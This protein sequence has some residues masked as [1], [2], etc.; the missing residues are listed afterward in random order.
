MSIKIRPYRKG[1]Y[2]VDIVIRLPNGQT[3]RER[4]KSPFAAK[5]ATTHWAKER[6]R[7]LL[8]HGLTPTQAPKKEV[9][10]LAEFI[11][12]YIEGYCKANRL[13][14]AT[15]CQR[16]TVSTIHLI[17][18]L[19][20]KRLDRIKPEDIQRL[21]A[22]RA[23]LENVTVNLML[24]MLRSVLNV[25]LEWGVIDKVPV[26]I[27]KLKE[28]PSA[29][30]FYD[31]DEFDKLVLAAERSADPNRL[32]SVLLGGEAGLRCSE[33]RPLTWSDLDLKRG[34]LTVSRALWRNHE[35]PPKSGRARMI[36][37]AP[38]LWDALRTHRH[39]RAPHILCTQRGTR[40]A[41]TTVRRWVLLAQRS[42]GIEEAGPHVLR[43]TFCSLLAMAGKPAKAIQELAGHQSITTTERYMHLAPEAARDAIEGLRRPPNWRHSGDGQF[44]VTKIQ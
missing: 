39:L 33:M 13:R 30:K 12:R 22:E 3:H 35:G 24:A 20:R 23:H 25:A 4:R 2:E 32:L 17:P 42:A 34:T 10:T 8:V 21:K 43:H 9:P 16:T 15:L 7:Y 44:G 18:I 36:P 6:E 31:F 41:A 1:G 5:S 37:L 38:R 29:F 40:P 27:K 28:A 19:G 26:R 11:P 14:P